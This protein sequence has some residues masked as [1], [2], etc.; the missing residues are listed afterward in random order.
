MRMLLYWLN[1]CYWISYYRTRQFALEYGPDMATVATY[2]LTLFD[3]VEEASKK[4]YA[5]TGV[6]L[7]YRYRQILLQIQ[8]EGSMACQVLLAGSLLGSADRAYS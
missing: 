1:P 2:G 6:S 4:W 8:R 5:E 3:G 7:P